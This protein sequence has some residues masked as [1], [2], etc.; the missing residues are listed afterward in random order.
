MKNSTHRLWGWN[1][2]LDSWRWRR[3]KKV[4]SLAIQ[5]LLKEDCPVPAF[6][7]NWC[8]ETKPP[9]GISGSIYV[10]WWVE[11]V[12]G[13]GIGMIILRAVLL[14]ASLLLDEW[15]SPG[16]I[17]VYMIIGGFVP[18]HILIVHRVSGRTA[19]RRWL[20]A[21][22]LGEKGMAQDEDESAA[23]RKNSSIPIGWSF[24]DELVSST[25]IKSI[26]RHLAWLWLCV[27]NLNG[28][29]STK[30]GLGQSR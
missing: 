22:G 12:E 28:R 29:W 23:G 6:V 10:V 14:K 19:R 13:I 1:G 11:A 26:L 17:H 4:I 7:G 8:D 21:V 16:P 5:R 27:E 24:C 9:V 2:W 20:A 25:L 15:N 18:F 3:W 30:H